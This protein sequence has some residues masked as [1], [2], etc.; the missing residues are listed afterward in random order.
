MEAA[1]LACNSIKDALPLRMSSAEQVSAHAPP[2]VTFP[3]DGGTGKVAA[4]KR[5]LLS[6][7]LGLSLLPARARA[8][9]EMSIQIGVP[10]S[11]PLVV[12]QPGIQVVEN[13]DEEV[14]F[15]SGWYWC[16]RGDYWY[17][18]RGPR[19]SFVYVEPRFVPYR[20]AY[21][22]PPGHYRRW[23][24]GQLR[25]E[26][27]WWREHDAERRHAWREHESVQRHGWRGEG[28]HDHGHRPGPA[29]APAHAYA[30]ASPARAYAPA[31]PGPAF[32][33]ASSRGGPAPAPA[34]GHGGGGGQD[35]H[36]GHDGPRHDPR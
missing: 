8:Q 2:R 35:E 32:A 25:D 26:H 20:L 10:V 5:L 18:A 13:L 22:P 21:L 28:G 30:P 36:H 16:R 24:R 19:A 11:P 14:F 3:W 9:V 1:S 7:A 12:V 33:P 34:R 4:M 31:R 15:V 17:R 23:N 27:R 6:L 29:P